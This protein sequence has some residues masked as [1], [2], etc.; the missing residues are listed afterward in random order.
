MS[1]EGDTPQRSE[2]EWAA[3]RARLQ[4]RL[5]RLKL[6][7]AA[8]TADPTTP[9]SMQGMAAGL[10]IASEFIAGIAVGGAIGYGIDRLFGTLPI[11]LVVFLMLGFAAG[12]LN[13]VRSTKPKDGVPPAAS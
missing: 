3:D 4:Q 8:A 9:G 12:V 11:G 6:E 10:K 5:D 7:Q 13:V 2:A 1:D